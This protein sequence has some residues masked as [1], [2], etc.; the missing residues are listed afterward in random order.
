MV[1][2]TGYAA[3]DFGIDITDDLSMAYGFYFH[4]ALGCFCPQTRCEQR[5]GQFTKFITDLLYITFTYYANNN[6]GGGSGLR[7]DSPAGVLG[8]GPW[9]NHL[10]PVW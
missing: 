7:L 3:P 2:S 5:I 6:Q 4:P 8:C 10:P 9:I 1:D